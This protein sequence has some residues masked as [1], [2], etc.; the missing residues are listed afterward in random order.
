MK[1]PL[2]DLPFE[3]GDEIEV[4]LELNSEALPKVCETCCVD[5]A[6]ALFNSRTVQVSLQDGT[7]M[8]EVL[9]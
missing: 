8:L 2:C 7:I 4:P 9:P 6:I 5:V 3:D 1:C